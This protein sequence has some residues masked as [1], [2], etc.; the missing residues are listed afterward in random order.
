MAD[1]KRALG[2]KGPKTESSQR[3]AATFGDYLDRH[4]RRLIVVFL[5]L[6]ALLRIGYWRETTLGYDPS[7]LT[8][9]ERYHHDMGV[10]IARGQLMQEHAFFRAPFYYYLLGALYRI[11]GPHV[12]AVVVLQIVLSVATCF[13]VYFLTRDLFGRNVGLIALAVTACYGPLIYF[14]TELLFETVL[15]FLCVLTWILLLRAERE[16][17]V[18]AFFVAGLVLGLAIITR[19][20]VA[21][22]AAMAG[23]F[24]AYRLRRELP[25]AAVA[26]CTLGLALGCLVPI[27]PVTLHNYLAE[28]DFVLRSPTG[29]VDRRTR[30]QIANDRSLEQRRGARYA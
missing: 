11:V 15:V 9:D 23:M 21:V 7:Q 30:L 20:N 28:R 12:A 8:I 3:I 17:H 27:A 18:H 22:F 1:R 6:G 19:P 4:H 14:A 13:L 2:G 25:L 26:K 16:K 5:V 10:K 24:L 29:A